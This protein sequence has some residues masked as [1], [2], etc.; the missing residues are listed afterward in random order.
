MKL[1]QIHECFCDETRL[2]IL[3]LLMRG[4]LCVCHIQKFL[5]LNQ[6]KASRH[7]SY[8]RERG[9]LTATRFENWM[10]YSVV[11]KITPELESNLK[12]LQDCLQEYP[13]F[14]HDLTHLP[15]IKKASQEA[16][17]K[18]RKLELVGQT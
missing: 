17:A 13:V 7:L 12:C 15:Q 3:N 4:P 9:L 18:L 10:I 1:I 6:V 14:Q 2:R 11:E 8:M 5:Q 16:R